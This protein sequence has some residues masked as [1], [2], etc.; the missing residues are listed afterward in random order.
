[1]LDKEAQLSP[2]VSTRPLQRPTKIARCT[3]VSMA[4]RIGLFIVCRSG[5]RRVVDAP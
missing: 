1:M 2:V 5:P 3:V 4:G